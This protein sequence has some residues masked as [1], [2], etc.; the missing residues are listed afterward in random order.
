MSELTWKAT[1]LD[2]AWD[3]LRNCV[4]P[5]RSWGWSCWLTGRL[6]CMHGLHHCRVKAACRCGCQGFFAAPA[7][8]EEQR[9][10]EAQVGSPRAGAS[11]KLQRP[12]GSAGH[13]LHLTGVTVAPK[14]V[15]EGSTAP[16]GSSHTTEPLSM[17]RAPQGI[18]V[19]WKGQ[20]DL[21][22]PTHPSSG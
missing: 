16:R 10:P 15:P 9:R 11:L 20:C 5:S 12:W 2:P 3:L 19:P 21:E 22:L 1:G 13:Q 14:P 7:L 17:L 4:V 6:G 18:S 8:L